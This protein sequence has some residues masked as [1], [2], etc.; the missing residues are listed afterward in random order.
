VTHWRGWLGLGCRLLLAGFLL[1]AGLAK[2]D[3]LAGSIRA[4]H[5]YRILPYGASQVVGVGLPFVELALGL[6]LLV[7]FATR[8]SAGVAG[9]LMVVF[10][11]GISAA[12]ARGLRI[13]CG[14]FGGGGDLAAGQS[15]TYFW[16]IA[17]DV[18]LLGAAG[19]LV[20]QRTTK[21]AVDDLIART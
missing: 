9:G 12:W 16:E 11:S 5:A 7:G 1:V 14:C 3:D 21:L 2:A 15:P 17:R 6:L 8:F 18:A 19:Y 10:V 4:V 20:H 13:D